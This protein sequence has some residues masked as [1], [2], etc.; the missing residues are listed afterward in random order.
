MLTLARTRF[1]SGEFQTLIV[2][3]EADAANVI[4]NASAPG[5][6]FASWNRAAKRAKGRMRADGPAC[7]AFIPNAGDLYRPGSPC[8][9]H[10][11]SDAAAKNETCKEGQEQQRSRMRATLHARPAIP[12]KH[13]AAVTATAPGTAA[14]R[15]TG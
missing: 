8:G 13:S 10:A 3:V 9:R 5:S 14:S 11:R 15:P 12:G 6:A 2:V 4:E 1:G 7:R